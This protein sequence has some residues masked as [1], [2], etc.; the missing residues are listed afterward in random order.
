M[1]HDGL[2]AEENPFPSANEISSEQYNRFVTHTN[3]PKLPTVKRLIALFLETYF[4][5]QKDKITVYTVTPRDAIAI[6]CVVVKMPNINMALSGF[7]GY[8]TTRDGSVVGRDEL[9]GYSNLDD[10]TAATQKSIKVS[11]APRILKGYTCRGRLEIDCLSEK[12]EARDEMALNVMSVLD[13]NRDLIADNDWFPMLAMQCVGYAEND[14]MTTITPKY[15]YLGTWS[16]DVEYSFSLELYHRFIT[17][18]TSQ[19]TLNDDLTDWAEAFPNHITTI[20][21]MKAPKINAPV[22]GDNRVTIKT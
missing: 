6:P 5:S 12:P 4:N 13:V 1:N 7:A 15:L 3:K 11:P 19:W 22:F 20:Q 17:S 9:D 2:Y 18:V 8:Q 21:G 10:R 14:F 16:Y